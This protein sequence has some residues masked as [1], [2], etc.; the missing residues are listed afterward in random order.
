MLTP[1]IASDDELHGSGYGLGMWNVEVDGHRYIGHGGGMVGYYAAVGCDLDEGLGAVV[2]ANGHGPWH[3]L[4]FH[5]LAVAR[6]AAA[7]VPL[8]VFTPPSPE[9]PLPEPAE[10]PPPEWHRYVG[11]YRCHNPWLPNLRVCWRASGLRAEFP[12]G[13]VWAADLP[14]TPLGDGLFRVGA[15][16]RSPERLRLDCMIGGVAV[17][18]TYSGCA[19]YRT[20][21][22]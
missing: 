9:P 7:G 3:E 4:T 6:A 19:L 2:L 8:P 15:D 10:P 1:F 21:T 5:M 22:P 17:R 18:A 14:L 13:D 20:F 11:H 16:E 12:S